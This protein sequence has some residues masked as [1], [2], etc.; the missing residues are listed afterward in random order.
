MKIGKATISPFKP[1]SDTK[2]FFTFTVFCGKELI[3]DC[4]LE[5]DR[6]NGVNL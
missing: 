3:A 2:G 5:L 6:G 1:W 4:I